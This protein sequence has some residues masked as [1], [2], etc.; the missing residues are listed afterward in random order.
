ML[1]NYEFL[2]EI[3]RRKRTANRLKDGER[4]AETKLRDDKKNSPLDL[5]CW[6]A[7]VQ[8]ER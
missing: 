5:Y 2:R 7:L 6:L 1:S 8:K 3:F 4:R